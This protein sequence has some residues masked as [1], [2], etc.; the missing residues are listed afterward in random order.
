MAELTKK[1]QEVLQA[2]GLGGDACWKHKQ[3]G[4]WVIYHWACEAIAHKH[5]IAFSLPTVIHADP[6]NKIATLLVSAKLGDHEE[7]SIG[8]AAPYNT[9]QSYPF[10][11]AE[12]RAKDRVIL[13]LVGL[14]GEAYSEEEADDFKKQPDEQPKPPPPGMFAPLTKTALEKKIREFFTELQ[15]CTDQSEVDGLLEAYKAPIIQCRDQHPV[16]Y[17][18]NGD[19]PGI[20]QYIKDRKAAIAQSEEYQA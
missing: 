8:E 12:K 11:M 17:K 20:N 4:K 18:G 9:T 5:K 13:K 15:N 10:A 1:L 3:S 16:W 6:A 2:C 14:H 19:Q 7:W